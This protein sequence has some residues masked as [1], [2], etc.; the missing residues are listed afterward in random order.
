M[1]LVGILDRI[2][3]VG[4]R[5]PLPAIL[6]LYLSL[7]ILFLSLLASLLSLQAPHPVTGDI[8]QATNLL[9]THGLHLILT[10]TVSN[11]I[12]FA[13]VGSVLV[14]M[15]GIGLADKSGLV[16]ALLRASIHKAPDKFLTFIVVLSGVLSNVAMDT[17]YV[18]LVPLA[19]MIFVSAGRHPLLGI[20][21]AFAG[22]SGGYSANLLIGP[23]DTILAGI[24]SEA[25]AIIDPERK[26]H[27]ASNYYFMLSSTILVAIVGTWVTEKVV[28]QKFS[29]SQESQ[30]STHTPLS[31]SERKAI[32]AVG[33]FTV[34]FIALILWGLLP[35]SGIL[36]DENGSVLSSPFIKG[37]VTVLA[38]YTGLCGVIYGHIAQTFKSGA[39][40]VNAME[41]TMAT[42][43]S[44]LILM[45]FAA[46]FINYFAWSQLGTLIAIGGAN[47]LGSLQINSG[48]LLVLFI[49]IA[50]F[51]NLFIGS[52]SAKW[53]LL[54]PVFVP[55]FMLIGISPEATQV[56]FRIG[57]S[58]TNI[59]TP[60]M[61]YFGV[62]VACA[63]QYGKHYG[64][65]TIAAMMVPYSVAFLLGWSLLL[66][67]WYIL[68]LPLGPGAGF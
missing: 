28:A 9:S 24:S 52:A 16:S 32:K 15:V 67:G 20:A 36:R 40:V 22:V 27:A 63:Q 38:I 37:I 62:I 45:F 56:A 5:L 1:N 31:P 23:V 60:L 35:E 8:I 51:I 14:A 30:T 53:A 50:A 66:V 42:M 46:Q 10:K 57:D 44:Y 7:G 2:E 39:D 25:A 65:G 11:F 68:G 29:S 18:V 21:A 41:S 47:F 49:F 43:A 55:M 4:N 17:G 6:F 19:A 48:V 64:M 13:P 58:S 12:Q 26:V 3:T 59:I 33:L 54:A 61:P 34:L